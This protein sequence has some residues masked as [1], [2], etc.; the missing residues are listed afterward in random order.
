MRFKYEFQ[1][2]ISLSDWMPSLSLFGCLGSH[3]LWLLP[4]HASAFLTKYYRHY[5]MQSWRRLASFFPWT[6]IASNHS[7][8]TVYANGSQDASHCGSVLSYLV[9]S[10]M[11]N[12]FCNPTSLLW[13]KTPVSTFQLILNN[14]FTK[15]WVGYGVTMNMDYCG[16]I[17]I[18]FYAKVFRSW[19]F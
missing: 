3:P 19:N 18:I 14:R 2:H 16:F 5:S 17:D 15:V 7:K 1:N 6:C 13:P 12:D 8:Y 10:Y 9:Q 11:K 4:R